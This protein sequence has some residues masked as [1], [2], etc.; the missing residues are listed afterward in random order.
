MEIE[1]KKWEIKDSEAIYKHANNKKISDNLRDA[2]P[3]PYTLN[4]AKDYIIN[5]LEGGEREKL[6]RAIVVDKEIVG[7]IGIFKRKDVYKKSAEIGYWLAEPYWGK[8]IMTKAVKEMCEHFFNDYD[9]VRIDAE[10]FEFNKA[11]MRVLE[12]AGFKLEGI[13]RRSIF[14]NGKIYDSYIFSLVK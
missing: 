6:V 10:V 8:G 3:H 4:D 2:F 1:L 7:S 12:K 9:A 11:S 5:S 13:K 14:K